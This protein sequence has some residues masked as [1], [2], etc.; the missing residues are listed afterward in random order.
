MPNN[1]EDMQGT[2]FQTIVKGTPGTLIPNNSEETNVCAHEVDSASTLQ[3]ASTLH[4]PLRSS[5]FLSVKC[6]KWC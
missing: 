1:N 4:R 6:C 3:S 2:H 5:G